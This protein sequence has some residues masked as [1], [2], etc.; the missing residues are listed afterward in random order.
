MKNRYALPATAIAAVLL[1]CALP[2]RG[3]ST[4][5]D[6]PGKQLV[7]TSC[8]QCHALAQVTR[9]GHD[10]EGWRNTVA[11]MV[12]AGAKLSPAQAD[13]VV[14]YLAKNFPARAGSTAVVVPGAVKVAFRE[15]VVPT[16]GSRP[17]DPLAA[18]D[19]SIW[20]TGQMANVLGRI[21]PKTGAIKEYHP[22]VPGSGPHGLVMD[23]DGDVWFTANFKAYIGKLDPRT[24]TF[25]EY[26]LD[27]AARDPHT[28]VF[29]HDGMLWF[30]VQGANM[31]GR[32]NPK[33]GERR[34]VSV[35]TPRANPYGMVVDSKNTVWFVEFGSNKIAS[36]DARTMAITEHEL[37]NAG[38][39][40][41]RVALG[42][43]DVLWYSDYARGYLGRFDPKTGRTTEY[44]SPGGRDSKPYAITYARGAIWYSESGVEPNTL[45]RFDP[46]T[47][48]FQS[49]TIPSGG[50]VVR[51]MM[52]TTDGKNLVLACSGANRVAL[53]EIAP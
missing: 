13:V 39:R 46:A 37:P 45:V 1:C 18:P 30:T 33:T 15:W 35:P 20:Y 28:P 48:K 24:G 34:L 50:G 36:I 5:P 10:R 52:P 22:T 42:P 44:P 21:D 6:G 47:E 40:P 38:A 32:L 4:L 11:M 31:V 25:T 7:E 3:Q 53:V 43:G 12:N 51:N 8:T 41:R 16:A 26:A 29:D 14:D 9:S 2:V 19:G 49:W 17:H 27:P 23:G